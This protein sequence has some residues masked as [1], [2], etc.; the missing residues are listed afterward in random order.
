MPKVAQLNGQAYEV[1]S[2]KGKLSC[3]TAFPDGTIKCRIARMKKN[4]ALLGQS[5]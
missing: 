5:T 2:A 4:E 1:N 3:Y